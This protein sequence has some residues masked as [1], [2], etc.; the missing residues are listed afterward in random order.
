MLVLQNNK[1]LGG[2]KKR[3]VILALQVVQSSGQ[4]LRELPAARTA[5]CSI[6]TKVVQIQESGS[7]TLRK[8]LKEIQIMTHCG[9]EHSASLPHKNQSINVTAWSRFTKER[10]VQHLPT[11]FLV[12]TTME[13]SILQLC[14]N[15]KAFPESH[16]AE[17]QGPGGAAG[18]SP[19]ANNY[20]LSF[21]SMLLNWSQPNIFSKAALCL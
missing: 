18:R 21:T 7:A 10:S 2:M 13:F 6:H 20:N 11:I 16:S 17:G 4:I 15:E 12:K 5:R 3:R 8:R 9:M 19:S 14:R 1:K